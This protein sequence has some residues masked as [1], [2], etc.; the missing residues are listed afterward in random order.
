MTAQTIFKYGL[1]WP[2]QPGDSPADSAL[3]IEM[4]CIKRGIGIGLE[5][6]YTTMRKLLWPWL[7]DHRW[8]RLCTR[9]LTRRGGKL[10]VFMGPKSTGKTNT[11]AWFGL[12]KWFCDPV[13]TCVLVSST[14]I[15]GLRLRVWGEIGKLWQEAVERFDWLPGHYLDSKLAITY[16][17]L[18]DGEFNDRK[19]RDMRSAIV[20][21]PCYQDN[22]F[23]GLGKYAG[24][25]QKNILLIA[26]EAQFMGGSFLSAFSNLDGNE[27]PQFIVLGNP[28]DV[29]D[30]LGRAAEPKDGW[31]AHEEPNK[32]EVW[33]TRFM[34][35]HCVNLIGT[36]SPNMDFP[37]DAPTRYKYLISRDKIKT[38]ESFYGRD[39]IEFYSQ[40]KGCMK[41]SQLAK[42]V[43]TRE[44][45][46]KGGAFEDVNWEGSERMRIG[47][48]DAAYGGDRCVCGYIE[49]GKDARGKTII[50]VVAP[51]VVPVKTG[52]GIT[53]EDSIALWVRGYCESHGIFPE[54]FFHDSTGRGSM[55]TALARAWSDKCNPVE[56]G[57]NPTDRPVCSDLYIYDRENMRRLKLCSEHYRKFVTELWFSVRYAIEAGQIR[58]LPQDVMDE[59]AMREWHRTKDDKIELETKVEMKE[60]SGRS[61]DLMDWLSICVEGARR[62]GFTIDKLANESAVSQAN[63]WMRD[64]AEKHR[65]FRQRGELIQV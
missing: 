57:G 6:H 51:S 22:R 12:C 38:T 43:I 36:D 62:R 4:A 32:T 3:R 2:I 60:R 54:N 65:A 49:V 48:M 35:G 13:N 27:N 25:K 29:M 64:L 30:S 53:P 41:I 34:D 21:I 44:L 15:R 24:I 50:N 9:E 45:C 61:P 55:G 5:H 14:D 33:D 23:V 11:A 16:E 19:V 59:G 17:S 26:D 46:E 63:E 58:N 47:G 52:P 1:D 56:F 39:S 18:M 31:T 28:C 8:Q 20:G 40:C 42:R 10:T 7:D 37:A